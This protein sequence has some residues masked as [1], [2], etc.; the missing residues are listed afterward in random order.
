[1]AYGVVRK[2]VPVQQ[3][4]ACDW[5]GGAKFPRH[6]LHSQILHSA[7]EL[8]LHMV[9][10]FLRVPP[11]LYIIDKGYDILALQLLHP[12]QMHRHSIS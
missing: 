4:Q 1:M 6:I 8:V 7:G 10:V 11:Y 5:E 3:A 12:G 9:T 2:R